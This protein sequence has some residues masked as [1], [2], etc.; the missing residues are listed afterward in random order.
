[1]AETPTPV[2]AAVITTL[3]A[4][5]AVEA[6]ATAIKEDIE[7]DESAKDGNSQRRNMDQSIDNNCIVV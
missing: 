7:S 1:M 4:A 3:E 6:A 5:A 2:I